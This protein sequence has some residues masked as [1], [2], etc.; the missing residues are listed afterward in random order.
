[1]IGDPAARLNAEDG[2][3]FRSRHSQ[4]EVRVRIGSCK[5]HPYC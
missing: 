3:C 4:V 1:M 2:Q 5:D